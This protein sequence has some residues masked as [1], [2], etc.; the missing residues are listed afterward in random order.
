MAKILAR[1]IVLIA[2]MNPTKM[3]LYIFATSSDTLLFYYNNYMEMNREKTLLVT[4][5]RNAACALQKFCWT[6][7]V[8]EPLWADRNGRFPQRYYIED[9]Q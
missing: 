9:K 1:S 4:V 6:T 5:W 8:C 3:A 2:E 7:I